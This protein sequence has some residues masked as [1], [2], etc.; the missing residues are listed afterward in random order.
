MSSK[1]IAI[2]ELH[3]TS[4]FFSNEQQKITSQVRFKKVHVACHIK[5]KHGIKKRA[6]TIATREL[7]L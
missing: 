1:R 7:V 4:E 5:R 2:N 3:S 6:L